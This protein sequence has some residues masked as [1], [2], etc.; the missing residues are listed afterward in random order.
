MRL[1]FLRIAVVFVFSAVTI[2]F[3]FRLFNIKISD[4]IMT[5]MSEEN[6]EI[7][8]YREVSEKFDI[9]NIMMVSVEMNSVYDELNEVESIRKSLYSLK[10]VRK[11]LSITNS[12]MVSSDEYEIK[13]GSLSTIF[14]LTSYNAAEVEKILENDSSLKDTF[15]SK[16]GK[17]IL[18]ILN[19]EDSKKVDMGSLL[20][21]IKKTLSGKTYY[22]TGLP[23]ANYEI[24]QTA[25]SDVV[26]ILPFA[27]LGIVVILLIMF[28]SF[29]GVLLPIVAVIISNAVAMGL[30]TIFSESFSTVTIMM[31]IILVGIG[32][33]NTVYLISR[34]NEEYRYDGDKNA[35]VARA[36]KKILT[37]VLMC[38]LTTVAGF[39][40]LITAR[41]IPV[42]QL[43]F[44]TSAGIIVSFLVAVVFMPALILIVKPRVKQSSDKE[45]RKSLWAAITLKVIKHK[46]LVSTLMTVIFLCF[47]LI[48]PGIKTESNLETYLGSTALTIK[49]SNFI[50][51]K[52]GGDKFINVYMKSSLE[53]GYKDFYYNRIQRDIQKYVLTIDSHFISRGLST[54]TS[55]VVKSFSGTEHIPGN[56]STMNQV[57]LII[58]NTP[59]LSK[60]LLKPQSESVI[61]VRISSNNDTQVQAILEKLNRFIESYVFK[62][63][64]KALLD[65]NDPKALKEYEKSLQ[66]FFVSRNISHAAEMFSMLAEHKKKSLSQVVTEYPENELYGKY[67]SFCENFS[68]QADEK[69][70]FSKNIKNEE[71]TETFANFLS[72]NEQTLR[73]RVFYEEL[74]KFFPTVQDGDL[75]EFSEYVN[76]SE[77]VTQTGSTRLYLKVTG[78]PIIRTFINSELL[79]G[80]MTS[81]FFSYLFILLMFI[82]SSRSFRTGLIASLPL[83]F[84]TV[85]NFGFI[86]LFN[87]SLNAGTITIASIV[88]GLAIDYSV[89]YVSRFREEFLKTMDIC[90]SL[91]ITSKTV[92]RAISTGAFT[93]LLGFF[94]LGFGNLGIMKQFGIISG[95]SILVSLLST[96][97]ILPI[98]FSS[99]KKETL[100]KILQKRKADKNEKKSFF[101]SVFNRYR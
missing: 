90:K 84:T 56:S 93:T 78:N 30:V 25:F 15:V 8:F 82:I 59:E 58:E 41:L 72:F 26:R 80:Q 11:V 83:L 64:D 40:S 66:S 23:L 88:I 7:S 71:Y 97:I 92:L 35:A 39:M 91:E 9:D 31:P 62:S 34:Y 70:I 1:K 100:L 61:D 18:Y 96:V 77:Y 33:D 67:Q 81:L 95:I 45:N 6:K 4:D 16:D 5:Y 17:N 69:S 54:F 85:I 49:G 68:L 48:I 28:R 32:V 57:F 60:F 86:R 99:I 55:S 36:R 47:I 19:L 27:I 50:N 38:T 94:P 24:A 43:G 53:E 2:F 44:Y 63:Y 13:S 3:A 76:D 29:S 12:V 89:H 98:V 52:F 46:V 42:T 75:A 101:L 22:L 87:F 65:I 74:K 73:S 14:D 21:E 51:E 37:P 79:Y 20:E 10:D